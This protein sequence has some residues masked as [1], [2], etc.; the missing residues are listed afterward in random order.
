MTINCTD[1]GMKELIMFARRPQFISE[2][3][4]LYKNAHLSLECD[5]T[6]GSHCR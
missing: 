3:P 6:V 2:A 1:K 4:V 5:T